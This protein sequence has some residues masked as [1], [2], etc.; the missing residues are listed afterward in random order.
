MI[1]HLEKK[2]WRKNVDKCWMISDKLINCFRNSTSF[3]SLQSSDKLVITDSIDKNYLY[4]YLNNWVNNNG[5]NQNQRSF[6][7][8]ESE[9]WKKDGL[10]LL[11]EE[12]NL[13]DLEECCK[14]TFNL[15]NLQGDYEWIGGS[16]SK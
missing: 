7:N 12:C 16:I 6:Y 3:A 11:K 8:P 14:Q 13:Y 1:R 15:N 2:N 9:F 4:A 5:F 10:N